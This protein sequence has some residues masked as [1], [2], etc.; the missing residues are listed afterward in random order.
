M[1]SPRYLLELQAAMEDNSFS[2]P[3][4]DTCYMCRMRRMMARIA[5]KV[6]ERTDLQE[7]QL[8]ITWAELVDIERKQMPSTN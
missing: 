5:K 1:I 2:C 4:G 3:H 7:D 8:I 6:L